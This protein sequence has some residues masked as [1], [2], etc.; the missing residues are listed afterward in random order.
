MYICDLILS[1]ISL[2]IAGDLHGFWNLE[3]NDLLRELNPDAILFVGDLGEGDFRLI[4]LINQ[5]TIPTAVILGN[6]D[7]GGDVTGEVLRNQLSLLGE[8]D[9]SWR[10]RNWDSP[11]I[12]VIGARPCSSGGGYFLAPAVQA[13]FGPVTIDQSIDR[14]VKASQKA[15]E[16]LPLVLLAHAGPTGLGSDARSL[17]GRDWK[18]PY[19][20]WGDKDL[21]ISITKIQKQRHLD[22][23]VFGHMHHKLKQGM[24][25]RD[26]F[27]SDNFGTAYL[28]T[29]SV[30]RRGITDS[31]E[32]L[33]HFSW[34]EFLNGKL[35]H[36][37]HRWY[38]TDA[39]IAYKETLFDGIQ[40]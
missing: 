30:P 6:H 21:E 38:R 3:D 31:G 19:I 37:S 34:V 13:V 20:D 9:C 28:N 8:R 32:V 40:R 4:K 7:R 25:Y 18:K 23:V 15:S 29:A 27:V 39:T 2:A 1:I 14:I 22:L 12:S 17:C 26:T 24:G 11:N 35:H 10:L 36:I 33:S 16:S 5:L